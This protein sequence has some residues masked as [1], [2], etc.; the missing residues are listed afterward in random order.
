MT[1][2]GNLAVD[3]GVMPIG[4]RMAA[5]SLQTRPV[6]FRPADFRPH[7]DEQG[8]VRGQAGAGPR[9]DK[10]KSHGSRSFQEVATN[11]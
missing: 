8:N 10:P 9:R 11:G 1:A 3:P 2:R 7:P 5:L 4:Q 6:R